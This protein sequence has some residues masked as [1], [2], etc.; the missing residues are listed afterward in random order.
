MGGAPLGETPRVVDSSGTGFDRT[1][2]WLSLQLKSCFINLQ[3][4]L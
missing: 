1:G 3:Q 2:F 4:P